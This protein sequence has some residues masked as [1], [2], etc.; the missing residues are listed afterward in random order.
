MKSL[1]LLISSALLSFGQLSG[2]SPDLNDLQKLLNDHKTE[3]DDLK[4]RFET[5]KK[6]HQKCHEDH[7]KCQEELHLLQNSL[8]TLKQEHFLP[9]GSWYLTGDASTTVKERAPIIFNKNEIESEIAGVDGHFILKRKGIYM[10]TFGVT[11][12]HDANSFELQLSG[13]LL[14]GGKLSTHFDGTLEY[15]TGSS[16]LIFAAPEGA[17]LQIVNVSGKNAKLGTGEKNS[18]AAH[19]SILQIR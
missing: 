2:K 15:G 4:N 3:R 18:V 1:L 12:T 16:T 7:Q 5:L 19:L 17:E 13:N 8:G 9:Y 14:P 6:E 10:V 11:T